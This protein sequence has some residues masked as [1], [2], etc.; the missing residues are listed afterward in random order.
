MKVCYGYKRDGEEN[1]ILIKDCTFDYD[2]V[3]GHIALRTYN[4]CDKF[5]DAE[6]FDEGNVYCQALENNPRKTFIKFVEAS[7]V[8]PTKYGLYVDRNGVEMDVKE[9]EATMHVHLTSDIGRALRLDD[10]ALK[11]WKGFKLIS[12]TIYV[13]ERK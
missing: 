6:K 8:Y 7:K 11:E 10:E 3:Q 5:K 1:P 9:G 13:E 4:L 12:K 2:R